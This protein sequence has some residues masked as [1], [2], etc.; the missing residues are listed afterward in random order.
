MTQDE[1]RNLIGKRSLA[2]I[3]G[4]GRG[5]RLFPLTL[6]RSKPAV[7]IGGKYR[8]IDIPISNCINSGISRIYVLT[9]FLSAGLNRHITRTYRFDSFGDRF[10][11][12]LAS[13][14]SPTNYQYA[15]GTA[16]AVRQSVRY[17]ESLD[18]DYV[19]VLSGDQ[20]CRINL[21]DMLACHHASGADVT[22]A[23]I[24]IHREDVA[25]CGI[26]STDHDN[27]IVDFAEK[28][29]EPAVIDRFKRSR[30]GGEYFWGS[31]GIYLFNK[32]TLLSVLKEY[33]DEHDFGKG[34]F[35]R[36]IRTHRI[37]AYEYRGYWEDIGTIRSY[38]K[39]SMDLLEADPPFSFYD[40]DMPVY[41]H[42]RNLPA[43]KVFRSAL[44][45][46]LVCEGSIL[47]ES[48]ISR[49]IIGIRTYMRSRCDCREAIIMGNDFYPPN[50]P[51]LTAEEK[52]HLPFGIKQSVTIR[53]A[54]IDKNVVIGS[55]S[56]ICGSDDATINRVNG[57]TAPYHIINGI[58]VIPRGTVLPDNTVIDANT[59]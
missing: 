1:I 45:R 38:F 15:Q 3:L 51:Y 33:P 46:T 43:P 22:L 8:L 49:A 12:I 32:Q 4:G 59:L 10:V 41:T 53:R 52:D 34:I 44:D 23:C 9:Q 50:F 26:V 14:Q 16:D 17:L 31:M 20:L 54:I 47:H 28:P 25:R 5:S 24:A 55:H 21:D 29:A 6:S 35:P 2:L 18:A 19:F 27:R 13:E 40:F 58:V 57:D 42:H 11:E 30:E 7:A 39:A 48:A 36:S 37:N 56:R